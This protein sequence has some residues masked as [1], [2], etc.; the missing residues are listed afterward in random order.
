MAGES[1][2]LRQASELVRAGR[3]QEALPRLLALVKADPQSEQAWLLLSTALSDPKQQRDCLQRVIKINPA[4]A[5]AAARLAKLAG[6]GAV[7][8]PPTAP[9]PSPVKAAP[10]T[11]LDEADLRSLATAASPLAT[12]AQSTP[13]DWLARLNPDLPPQKPAA[14]ALPGAVQ[15]EK[16]TASWARPQP[17]APSQTGKSSGRRPVEMAVIVLLVVSILGCGLAALFAFQTYLAQLG[18]P[19]VAA[20]PTASP[21]PYPTFPPAWTPTAAVATPAPS[22]LPAT[23]PAAGTAIANATP[24]A[25]RAPTQPPTPNSTMRVTMDLIQQ[26]VADIRGLAIQGDVPRYLISKYRLETTARGLLVSP[27]Y[28]A[29]LKN[30]ACVY[31]TLGL[32]KPT[33]DLAK[34][35]LNSQL[36]SIGGF[37]VPWTKQL[38]VVGDKFSGLEHY[39][40]AH[41]YDHALTDQHFGFSQLGIYPGCVGDAQ[42]CRA[43][44]ALVE[45]DA[46]LLMNLWWQQ[47][48][49]PQDY[50]DLKNYQPPQQAL[51]EQFPPPFALRDGDLSYKAG[52]AF[53]KFLHER[54]N[55][56]EVNQ[57]YTNLPQSTEQIL[58]PAKYVAGEAPKAVSA[59]PLTDTLG[60]D[61]Q[62]LDDNSL[63]EWMTYLILGYGADVAAQLDDEAA[64]KAAA[65]WGGDRYQ[66]LYS[67]TLSSTVLAAQWVW[68]TPGDLKEF[69]TAIQFYLNERFRGAKIKDRTDGDCWEANDQAACL[70]VKNQ[71]TLWLLAP[72]Q[73][74]I[75]A[76]LAEYP[77]FR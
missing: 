30:M 6:T 44:R 75:N 29:E 68:D 32:I 10:F 7:P 62:Q 37:Y 45:G 70:F 61:W 35:A 64:A 67:D 11:G 38:V 24:S 40:F 21:A 14:S 63:G 74:T 27:D 19:P 48:A 2:T 41:E 4:N 9:R 54:G 1:D 13:T 3:P 18:A 43:I 65:G 15:T 25:T 47:Y 73:T 59:P 34:Y 22:A 39:I 12:P 17:T 77:D 60:G 55:W 26:Q 56:A 31:T 72:D 8:P 20:L 42:R 53:V 23:Q 57:A 5:E 49:S 28:Q 52:Y 36:D 50:A 16:P 66:I 33:Y 46:T 69:K 51:P 58:H 71:S 76:V